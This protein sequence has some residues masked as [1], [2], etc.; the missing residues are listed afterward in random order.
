MAYER[1]EVPIAKS[2]AQIRALI[3]KRKGAKIGF[4]E[5]PPR[6]SFVAQIEL[7]GIAYQIRITATAKPARTQS[8]RETEERRIWR[9]LYNHL[10]MIFESSDSGLMELRE[11]MLPYIVTKTGQTV[12]EMLVPQLDKVIETNPAR[13]L[14]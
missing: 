4:L 12:A 6:H 2:Q 11:I 13:L 5:E 1:T 7:E 9:V 3:I 8:G 14:Q 10:K